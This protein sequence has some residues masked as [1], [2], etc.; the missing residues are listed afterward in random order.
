MGIKFVTFGFGTG[1]RALVA[2][3]QAIVTG[4]SWAT[5]SLARAVASVNSAVHGW[6][7]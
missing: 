6:W 4:R 7:A 2:L 5:K 1:M 3:E